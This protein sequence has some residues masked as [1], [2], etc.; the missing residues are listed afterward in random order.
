MVLPLPLRPSRRDDRAA[1]NGRDRPGRVRL[2]SP[3][4][5]VRPLASKTVS[6]IQSSSTSS[7]SSA[8]SSIFAK[9]ARPPR[10]VRRPSWRTLDRGGTQRGSRAARAA[11][12]AAGPCPPSTHH[13][14][15]TRG[16][17]RAAPSSSSRPSALLT[18]IGLTP[19]LADSARVEGISSPG[20]QQAAGHVETD[21]LHRAGGRPGFRCGDR[22]PRSCALRSRCMAHV[23]HSVWSVSRRRVYVN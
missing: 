13:V 2:S 9:A 15:S 19:N 17:A 14:G 21:L 5:F 16:A 7:A 12:R 11:W 4:R 6:M 23:I 10:P 22:R 8:S 20:W 1:P 3:N 18:V